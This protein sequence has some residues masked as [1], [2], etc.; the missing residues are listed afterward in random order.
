MRTL[1]IALALIASANVNA[2][3][4][5]HYIKGRAKAELTKIQAM[6]ELLTTDNKSEIYKCVQ[7]ELSNKGTV[8]N[9]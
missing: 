6:K 4:G 8:K 3:E 9:K 1:I 2:A 7:V 5:E